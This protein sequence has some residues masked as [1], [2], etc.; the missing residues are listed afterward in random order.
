[1]EKYYP[2]QMLMAKSSVLVAPFG[3][4]V[5][6]DSGCV[7][8]VS[9][10]HCHAEQLAAAFKCGAVDDNGFSMESFHHSNK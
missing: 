10:R 6:D 8:Q 3:S 2:S 9:E 4:D 5:L 1:M 7:E